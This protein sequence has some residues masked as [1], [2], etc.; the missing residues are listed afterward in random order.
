MTYATRIP[1]IRVIIEITFHSYNT[2]F[3]PYSSLTVMVANIIDKI[4]KIISIMVTINSA[5]LL[6]CAIKPTDLSASPIF[7]QI[8]E[9]IQTSK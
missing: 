5:V 8:T 1:N 2:L 4:F 9:G 3:F 7:K 6:Q